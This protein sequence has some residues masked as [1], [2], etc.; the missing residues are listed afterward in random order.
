MRRHL[1]HIYADCDSYTLVVGLVSKRKS[2][3]VSVEHNSRTGGLPV[4]TEIHF[5]D[6][7]GTKRGCAFVV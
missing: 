6:R 5:S 1:L 7:F 4:F 3:N 2:P